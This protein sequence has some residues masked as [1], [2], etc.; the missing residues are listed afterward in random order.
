MHG[1]EKDAPEN[2]GRPES[3]HTP[4]QMHEICVTEKRQPHTQKLQEPSRCTKSQLSKMG[5]IP[6]E[7]VEDTL[8]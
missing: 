3:L 7:I 4:T 1:A 6:W 8:R 5:G 2:A